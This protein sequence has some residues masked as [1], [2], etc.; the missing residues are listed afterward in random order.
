MFQRFYA[1]AGNT[2][3]AAGVSEEMLEQMAKQSLNPKY[4]GIER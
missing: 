3:T 2:G 4:S 1:A